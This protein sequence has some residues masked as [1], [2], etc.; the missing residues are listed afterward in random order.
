MK[1]TVWSAISVNQIDGSYY[2]DSLMVIVESYKHLLA[3][4]FFK[5][6]PV[7]PEIQCYKKWAP[8]HYSSK[9]RQV[10]DKILPNV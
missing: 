9:V 7:Y 8:S 2:F 4:F 1:K 5:C 3:I 10:L 6:Y